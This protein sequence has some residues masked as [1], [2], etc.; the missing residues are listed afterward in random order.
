[1][2]AQ[3][4]SASLAAARAATRAY[5]T[6][7]VSRHGPTPRGVDW[8]CELTQQ[9]RFVQLLKVCD[10][11][12]PF[13]L[14]DVGCGYGALLGFLR[15]RH[16]GTSIDYAGVDLSAAMIDAAQRQWKADRAA[17]S[18]G[19]DSQRTADYCVASGIFNVKLAVPTRQWRALVRDTLQRMRARSRKGIAVNFLLPAAQASRRLPEL[20]RPRAHTWSTYCR[21]V[22]GGDVQ[23]VEGYGLDEVTLLVRW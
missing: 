17:F 19:F 4:G 5:Y 16:A 9:L 21:D 14:N 10:F 7:V 15:A 20:Y 2:P 1:M 3:S 13:S 6:G 11:G 8:A 22:L 23:T 18:V 12:A